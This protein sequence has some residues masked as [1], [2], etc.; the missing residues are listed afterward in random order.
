MKR[1]SPSLPLVVVGQLL[2][3][4]LHHHKFLLAIITVLATIITCLSSD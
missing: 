4:C 1:P 2:L 3:L